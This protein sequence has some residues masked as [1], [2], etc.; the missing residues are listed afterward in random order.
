MLHPD[1]P[2]D[3]SQIVLPVIEG[4]EPADGHEAIRMA[5]EWYLLRGQ[6]VACGLNYLAANSVVSS[7]L[8]PAD[9]VGALMSGIPELHHHALVSILASFDTLIREQAGDGPGHLSDDMSSAAMEVSA[10]AEAHTHD[11]LAALYLAATVLMGR[12]LAVVFRAFALLQITIDSG[13]EVTEWSKDDA[14]E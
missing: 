12:R 11:E 10:W 5:K 1:L 7:D 9:N 8:S 2:G 4:Q 13:Y 3:L 14:S 6:D